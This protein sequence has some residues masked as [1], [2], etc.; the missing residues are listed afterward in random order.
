MRVERDSLIGWLITMVFTSAAAAWGTVDPWLKV[1]FFLMLLDILAGTWRNWSSGTLSLQVATDGANKKVMIAILVTASIVVQYYV[2]E[3]I[4]YMAPLT[5]AVAGFYAAREFLSILRHAHAVGLG[6]P[7]SL[8]DVGERIEQ[9]TGGE[10][11]RQKEA[12]D[13]SRS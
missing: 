1:L 9:M 11:G 13:A 3:A 2:A 4:G 7:R 6:I 10:V 8:V 12:N 5:T